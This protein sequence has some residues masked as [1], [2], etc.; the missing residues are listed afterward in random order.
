MPIGRSVDAIIFIIIIDD[1]N[2]F[3][4][5]ILPQEIIGPNADEEG[6]QNVLS[7]VYGARVLAVIWL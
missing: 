1:H 7:G 6:F 2:N 5:F 3:L 4:F